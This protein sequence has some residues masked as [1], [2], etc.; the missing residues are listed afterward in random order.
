[1]CFT[2]LIMFFNILLLFY[3]ILWLCF[4]TFYDYVFCR[5]NM[6]S[7]I[8]AC[9]SILYPETYVIWETH[10]Y[11]SFVKEYSIHHF[12]VSVPA[13]PGNYSVP[14]DLC[15]PANKPGWVFAQVD[16][17]HCVSDVVNHCQASKRLYVHEV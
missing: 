12:M 3:N 11:D 1:M 13:L 8:E 5:P 14:W 7:Y 17:C 9:W 4:S 16:Q 6:T 10:N 15:Y 2:L